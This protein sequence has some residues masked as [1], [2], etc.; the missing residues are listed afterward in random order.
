MRGAPWPFCWGQRGRPQTCCVGGGLYPAP[1]AAAE[2]PSTPSGADAAASHDD[3]FNWDALRAE[4]E[5]STQQPSEPTF[6]WE[7]FQNEIALQQRGSELDGYAN[8]L[9]EAYQALD[10]ERDALKVEQ[11]I[12]RLSKEN[13]DFARQDKQVQLG[14]FSSIYHASEMAREVWL[15]GDE[16]TQKTL[17]REVLRYLG[18]YA[19]RSRPYQQERD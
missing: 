9:N 14:I 3:G 1:E 13:A 16:A 2:A 6:N 11:L 18:N 17:E 7:Q 12:G 8:Q 19:A 10:Y 4:F 15:N 5:G